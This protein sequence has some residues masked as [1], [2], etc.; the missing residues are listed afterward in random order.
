MAARIWRASK[1]PYAARGASA[2]CRSF[3]FTMALS[4]S[5]S[6]KGRSLRGTQFS[7]LSP[8]GGLKNLRRLHLDVAPDCD[9]SPLAGLKNLNSLCT[10]DAPVSDLSPLAELEDLERLDLNGRHVRDLSPLAE[11]TNLHFLNLHGALVSD[12]SALAGLKN[13]REL[14]VG[15]ASVRDLSPRGRTEVPA[16]ALPQ[17]PACQRPLATG[18]TQ[19]PARTRFPRQLPVA[20]RANPTAPP[21]APLLRDLLTT[22]LARR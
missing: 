2:T 1:R 18:R 22:E 20:R 5:P 17:W 16:K 14:Y 15:E 7:D 3:I 8:I 11:L 19:E 21:G 10:G 6:R 13:L 9:L 12:L 4:S